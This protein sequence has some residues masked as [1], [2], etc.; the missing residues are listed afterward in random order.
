MEIIQ[1]NGI[2]VRFTTPLMICYF[3]QPPCCIER[4]RIRCD[5]FHLVGYLQSVNMSEAACLASILALK[6]F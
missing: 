5:I 3:V 4:S 6:R 2:P 1:V